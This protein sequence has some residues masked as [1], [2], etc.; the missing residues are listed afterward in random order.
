MA[1]WI[2][3]I[4]QRQPYTGF[5]F[6]CDYGKQF[7]EN[8]GIHSSQLHFYRVSDG[9]RYNE[10]M[11]AAFQDKTVQAP[12]RDGTF[13]FG[14]NYT[15]RTFNIQIAFDS[16]TEDDIHEFKRI[17][18]AKQEGDLIF[19]E[20]PYKQYHVKIQN[21]PQIKYIVFEDVNDSNGPSKLIHTADLDSNEVSDESWRQNGRT[22]KGEGTIQF[23]A[24][25]PFAIERYGKY[26]YL[27]DYCDGTNM[28]TNPYK[29]KDKI[30]R[31][32]VNYVVIKDDSTNFDTLRIT[33]DSGARPTQSYFYFSEFNSVVLK[34]NTTYY[35]NRPRKSGI[36]FALNYRK[37][38][39]Q[40]NNVSARAITAY[41]SPNVASWVSYSTDKDM[42]VY[43]VV[44]VA[45]TSDT[46]AASFTTDFFPVLVQSDTT[47]TIDMT[48]MT[49]L[50]NAYG[51]GLYNGNPL[52]LSFDFNTWKDA[53]NMAKQ[54][55]DTD[56]FDN[57]MAF[58]TPITISSPEEDSL[59]NIIF[60]KYETVAKVVNAGEVDSDVV[61]YFAISST[62][63]NR[64]PS[65][66]RLMKRYTGNN[67]YYDNTETIF[68]NVDVIYFNNKITGLDGDTYIR[69]NSKTNLLEGGIWTTD[70][71]TL[72]SY[73]K[74][75]GNIYNRYITSG[76]FFKIPAYEPGA[77]YYI[78]A[79]PVLSSA[80]A[81]S[82]SETLANLRSL[83]RFI[84]YH[85][86]WY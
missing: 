62:A 46:E 71:M 4:P 45:S 44:T 83:D 18:A 64:H 12:G 17:F 65:S 1:E 10:D 49:A 43:G 79:M 26:K 41:G 63:Q 82:A 69:Y 30:S 9:N 3:R 57:N 78:C 21:P 28:I 39:K 51:I 74:P 86:V 59:G 60:Q 56:T 76:N 32:G 81:S 52:P 67:D 5:E 35:L 6:F 42:R 27:A 34:A 58:D 53:S 31:S 11:S 50:H 38:N 80:E 37:L 25:Y 23:V 33:A 24:Y 8:I 20:T 72:N 2:D 19:D 85:H 29:D 40:G 61:F 55:A 15:S 36:N 75:S 77:I 70:T 14:T 47:P 48:N 68:Q 54:Q 66:I 84:E 73:F 16:M 22:Y 7:Q 13:Y